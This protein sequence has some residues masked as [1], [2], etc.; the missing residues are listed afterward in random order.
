MDPF[1]SSM[2]T[3]DRLRAEGWAK[4]WAES[5]AL[6]WANSL[7]EQLSEKFGPLPEGVTEAIQSADLTQLRRWSRRVLS[8]ST[9]S[10][11]MDS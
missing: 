7:F 9:L 10:D 1:K 6:G 3:A 11:V 5:R 2:T 8:A 4:G